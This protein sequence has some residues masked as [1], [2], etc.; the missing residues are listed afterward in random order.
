MRGVFPGDIVLV[1]AIQTDRRGRREGMLIEV[2]ERNTH[3]ILGRYFEESGL[4]FISPSIKNIAQDIV[5]PQD[6]RNSAQHG[7]YVMAEIISQPTTRRQAMGRVVEVLGEHMAPGMEIEVA[8][9]AHGIPHEWPEDV[10]AEAAKF[11]H[12]D[13]ELDA[14]GRKDIR[15]LPLVTIDSEDAKDFDDAVHCKANPK[16]GWTLWVAIADVSHYVSPQTAIDMEAKGRGNSVYFPGR[17]VPMLSEVLS[18]G[19]CSLKPKVDRYCMVCEMNIDAQGHV[20]DFSFYPAVMRSH[21]RL[22]YTEVA[23]MIEGRKKRD[24]SLWPHLE[25]LHQLFLVLQKQRKVRGALEFDTVETRI[26]F[27]KQRKIKD[28][29]PVVRNDAHRLIEECM[30]LANV[31]AAKFLLDHKVPALFRVHEGPNPDK[32]ETLRDFMA[33]F[34]LSLKGGDKPDP[35]DY[36]KLI[37]SISG[38]PDEHLIQTVLL[39][40]LQQ[41]V[42]APDNLG[43]FGLAY[44]AYGH[45]ASPI[46]RYP[47]LLVHRAIRHILS[48]GQMKDFNYSLPQMHDFGSHCSMTERR[49]DDATR[50]VM[51]WLKCEF[52]RDKVGEV[53]DGKITGVTSFG[54][55][56]SLEKV[57]VEGLVHITA[58]KNDYY[59]F[60]ATHH[61]L[62]GKRSNTQYRLGDTLKVLVARVDLDDRQIDFELA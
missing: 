58:L 33:G 42:Y 54:I 5:I 26:V 38:R 3:N 31:S 2:L 46:R 13:K 32:L 44:E 53:F 37:E 34:G 57:Y 49:A 41:A 10:M 23:G 39:R 11:K 6:Q 62:K 40:S 48:G 19:L 56:V 52:M 30:L 17:V 7:Q 50:D 24:P 1:R 18:N 43:H 28:I 29:V 55:F 51:D 36:A 15:S 20:K 59:E 27:D 47:D 8:I 60:D 16:G 22:T 9:R 45:F 14:T 21:A 12:L 4:S 25:S 35:K 61:L